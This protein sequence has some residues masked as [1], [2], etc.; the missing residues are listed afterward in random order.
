MDGLFLLGDTNMSEE[1]Q[2]NIDDDENQTTPTATDPVEP[3]D[4]EGGISSGSESGQQDTTD[5]LNTE[6]SS[7]ASDTSDSSSEDESAE[8]E[9]LPH[10][11]QSPNTIRTKIA[12][13]GIDADTVEKLKAMDID[14]RW[15]CDNRI[16]TWKWGLVNMAYDFNFIHKGG[17]VNDTDDRLLKIEGDVDTEDGAIRQ[18]IGTRDIKYNGQGLQIDTSRETE[19]GESSSSN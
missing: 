19:E 17:I 11:N 5:D 15:Q 1:Q 4:N 7:G 3:Q 18:Q 10:Y 2:N 14:R 16:P 8:S 6:E 9:A 12:C 13:N